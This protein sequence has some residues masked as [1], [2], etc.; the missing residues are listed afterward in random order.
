MRY[1]ASSVSSMNR[2]APSKLGQI[3]RADQRRKDGEVAAEQRAARAPGAEGADRVALRQAIVRALRSTPGRRLGVEDKTAERIPRQ[4]SPGAGG[5]GA[6]DAGAVRPCGEREMKRGDV[7]EADQELGIGPD[8]IEIEMREDAGAAPAAA[9][10][11]NGADLPVGEHR[12]EVGGAL[13]VRAGEIAVAAQEMRGELGDQAHGADRRLDLRKIEGV[14]G[15]IGRL[16][17]ADCV[18]L[19][20][21]EGLAARRQRCGNCRRGREEQGGGRRMHH[22]PSTEH[23]ASLSIILAIAAATPV[24]GR[25]SGGKLPWTSWLRSGGQQAGRSAESPAIARQR[26]SERCHAR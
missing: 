5:I 26:R 21:S 10:R 18:T 23:P 17:E 25:T 12:I 6:M 3:G 11:E 13:L 19:P 4:P 7:A 20:E 9:H 22:G 2:I 15:E 14:G 16:H 24:I 8:P 1:C